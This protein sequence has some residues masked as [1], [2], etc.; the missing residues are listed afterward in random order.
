M[1]HSSPLSAGLRVPQ[2]L[3]SHD[4]RRGATR[5]TLIGMSVRP[6]CFA[7][8]RRPATP[9]GVTG[10]GGGGFFGV[11]RAG[12]EARVSVAGVAGVLTLGGDD[13]PD[14]LGDLPPVLG[15][16]WAGGST[17]R[18]VLQAGE[19]ADGVG[20][21]R[22]LGGFPIAGDLARVCGPGG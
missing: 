3:G 17:L 15:D 11:L 1:A 14:R 4:E 8:E 12:Q 13:V 19:G 22:G 20:V 2:T 16:A 21:G 10:R 18:A 7:D 6:A 5:C 9:R